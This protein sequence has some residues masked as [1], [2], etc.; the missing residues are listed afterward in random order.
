MVT[1]LD[2]TGTKSNYQED[3]IF[4]GTGQRQ[5]L[6]GFVSGFSSLLLVAVCCYCH[7]CLTFY[8]YF[9][10]CLQLYIGPLFFPSSLLLWFV[11]SFGPFK[12]NAPPNPQHQPRKATIFEKKKKNPFAFAPTFSK[13]NQCFRDLDWALQALGCGVKFISFSLTFLFHSFASHF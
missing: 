9:I 3:P 11:Q 5:R 6:P 8:A 12:A 2:T 13:I 10:G 7:F 1:V 4:V